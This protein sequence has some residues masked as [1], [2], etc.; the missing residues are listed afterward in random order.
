MN[1]I[2]KIFCCNCNSHSIIWN[3]NDFLNP[4][5]GEGVGDAF[6]GT[7][8]MMPIMSKFLT[9][10]ID[11]IL[12]VCMHGPSIFLFKIRV[13]YL[14]A[15]W[16]AICYAF[17]SGNICNNIIKARR[18][19]WM[20]GVLKMDQQIELERERTERLRWYKKQ[21]WAKTCVNE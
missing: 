5:N 6:N 19:L 16:A 21:W 3:G 17:S 7:N 15:F 10:T 8:I 12:L 18:H 9:G 4:W 11:I 2:E 20:T 13:Q 1:V 14:W